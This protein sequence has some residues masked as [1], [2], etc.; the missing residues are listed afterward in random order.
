MNGVTTRAYGERLAEQM[1]YLSRLVQETS[2][3]QPAIGCYVARHNRRHPDRGR[4]LKFAVREWP[5]NNLSLMVER[6]IRGL[7]RR[8][9]VPER[10][11]S[12][13]RSWADR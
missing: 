1:A 4:H 9:R 2:G 11:V 13:S 8:G 6:M 3:H 7:D 10:G 5:G 12:N